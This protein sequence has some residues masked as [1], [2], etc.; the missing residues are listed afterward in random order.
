[1]LQTG[2]TRPVKTKETLGML[3][4]GSKSPVKIIERMRSLGSSSSKKF[5]V[6]RDFNTQKQANGHPQNESGGYKG[7]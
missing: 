7:I 4:T 1:M 6:Q 2:S 5:I 3:Q